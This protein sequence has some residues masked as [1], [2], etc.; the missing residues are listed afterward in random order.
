MVPLKGRLQVL[1]LLPEASLDV[2][3]GTQDT[4]GEPFQKA[5]H[6]GMPSVSSTHLGCF[7]LHIKDKL[8]AKGMGRKKQILC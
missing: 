7:T 8:I 5:Q 2:S 1:C 3:R 4:K 6:L